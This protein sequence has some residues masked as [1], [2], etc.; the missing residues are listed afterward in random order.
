MRSFRPV[1]ISQW[2]NLVTRRQ[3]RGPFCHM[4]NR[5]IMEDEPHE[6]SKKHGYELVENTV[7]MPKSQALVRVFHHNDEEV[8]RVD[9]GEDNWDDEMLSRAIQRVQWFKPKEQVKT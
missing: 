2:E 4:C 7:G 9:L 6:G 3:V 5:W 8:A 1:Q